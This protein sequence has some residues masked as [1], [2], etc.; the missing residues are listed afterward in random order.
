MRLYPSGTQSETLEC[1]LWGFLFET[2]IEGK[3][4]MNEPKDI[5]IRIQ[6]MEEYLDCILEKKKDD[7]WNIQEDIE[8]QKM[9]RE[10]IGYYESGKWLADYECDE[11]GELPKD[12]KRGVLAQDTLYD[13]FSE[14]EL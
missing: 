3:I 6:K 10:L 2:K 1:Q 7:F 5:V 14:F 8:A 4:R 13:L 9:L 11:R 12:L